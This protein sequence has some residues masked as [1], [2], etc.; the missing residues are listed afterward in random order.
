MKVDEIE[1]KRNVKCGHLNTLGRCKI[2]KDRPQSCADFVCMWA[3][4]ALPRDLQPE[5]IHAVGDTTL[6]GKV[7]VFHIDARYPNAEKSGPLRKFIDMVTEKTEIIIFCVEG[8]KPRRVY[9]QNAQE[10]VSKVLGEAHAN[11]PNGN[12]AG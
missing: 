2:Y 5:K 9:G 10:F 4:G 11:Q 6:D 7:L 8:D 12:P 3:K 1:K